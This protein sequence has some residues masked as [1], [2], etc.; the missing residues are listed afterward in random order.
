MQI[1][2]MTKTKKQHRHIYGQA[3]HSMVGK[4]FNTSGE[5][6]HGCHSKN[7]N[8]FTIACNFID[9]PSLFSTMQGCVI[10]LLIVANVKCNCCECQ[11]QLLLMSFASQISHDKVVE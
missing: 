11:M 2:F 8:Y 7:A 9:I 1:C 5:D 3:Y 6:W 10:R 4:I